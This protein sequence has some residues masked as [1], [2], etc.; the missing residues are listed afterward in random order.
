M[1]LTITFSLLLQRIHALLIPTLMLKAQ[2]LT[3]LSRMNTLL[4]MFVN[5]ADSISLGTPNTKNHYGLKAGLH[6]FAKQGNDALMKELCQFHM[7]KCFTPKDPKTLSHDNKHNALASLMFLT[8]KQSGVI[9]A[10]GC[11]D[12]SKQRDH[13]TKEEAT[14]SNVTLDTIFLQATIFAHKKRKVASCDIPG[15]FLQANNLDY[16]LMRLDGILAELMVT[17]APNIYCKIHYHQRKG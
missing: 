7:L 4:H 6:K 17:V 3:S 8:E 9:K 12:G 1:V 16:V 10:R 15:A 2:Q 5:C 13:I 14:A 11:A